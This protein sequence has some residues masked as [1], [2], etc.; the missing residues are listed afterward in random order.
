MVFTQL[1]AVIYNMSTIKSLKGASE[2]L[3]NNCPPTKNLIFKTFA[4][5]V[6]YSYEI[7]QSQERLRFIQND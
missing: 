3:P 7:P 2:N 1:R 4:L 5:L 6:A